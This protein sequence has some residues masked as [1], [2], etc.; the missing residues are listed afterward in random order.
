MA[1]TKVRDMERTRSVR[2]F[3]K[4]G[5]TTKIPDLWQVQEAAYERFL[6][7]DKNPDERDPELGLESL[8]RE[9]FPIESYDETMSLE[10]ASYSLEQPRYT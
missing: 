2:S 3:A 6:Q 1:A 8:L 5:D 7:I 9:I 4:R 10:Y